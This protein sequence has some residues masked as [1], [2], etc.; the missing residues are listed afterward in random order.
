MILS[1]LRTPNRREEIIARLCADQTRE[2]VSDSLATPQTPGD[3][4]G[5]VLPSSFHLDA[6]PMGGAINSPLPTI[7]IPGIVPPTRYGPGPA[8]GAY[9]SVQKEN[10]IDQVSCGVASQNQT[11]STSSY[12][13]PDVMQ[14]MSKIQPH[15]ETSSWLNQVLTPPKSSMRKVSLDTW[16]NATTDGFLVQHLLALYFSWEY[17]AFACLSKEHFFKDFDDGRHRYCSPI[18][19]NALL[20]LGAR[21]SSQ[22]NTRTDPDNPHTSGNHFF[23]EFK[24]LFHRETSHHSL[25]TIQALG[26]ISSREASHAR[27]SESSYYARQSIRIAIEM[28]LHKVDDH[29]DADL[30]AV[31]TATFWGAFS[32]D[33][34]WSLATGSLPQC[35]ILPHHM[36]PKP[37]FIEEIDATLW[38][39]YTEDGELSSAGA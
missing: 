5:V 12:S 4:V 8:S 7:G 38:V 36:P 19:V 37:A 24:T 33:Q 34:A 10:Y 29:G 18:L 9:A 22:P 1:A 23:E 28:G 14:W 26:I 21:F 32:L 11:Q 35:S 6:R 3:G 27:Y 2:E 16:T 15:T 30:L 20:A 17:P 13:H 39:S 31:Q 25:T